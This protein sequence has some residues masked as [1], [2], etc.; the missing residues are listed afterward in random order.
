MRYAILCIAGDLTGLTMAD[1]RKRL[2]NEGDGAAEAGAAPVGRTPA[3]ARYVAQRELAVALGTTSDLE[4]ALGRCLELALEASEMQGGGIYLCTEDGGIDLACHRGLEPPFVAQVRRFEPSSLNARIVQR[5]LPAY[6]DAGQLRDAGTPYGLDPQIR[7]LAALPFSHQERRLGVI[8]VVSHGLSEVPLDARTVLEGLAA[9]MGGAVA[10]LQSEAALRRSERH[11]RLLAENLPDIVIIMDPEGRLAYCNPQVGLYGYDPDEEQGQHFSKFMARAEDRAKAGQCMDRLL[12]Q[13]LPVTADLLFQPRKAEPFAVEFSLRLF[14]ED[15]GRRFVFCVLRDISKRKRAEEA[16]RRSE[17][18]YRST[19]EAMDEAVFVLDRSQRLTMF[20][21]ELLRWR[22]KHGLGGGALMAQPVAEV[23]PFLE[24]R[25]LARWRQAFDSGRSVESSSCAITNYGPVHTEIR[26][27]PVEEEGE[28]ASLVV[29]VRDVTARIEAEEER[30]RL[31]ENLRE[32]Q[33]IESLGRLAGGVAHDLN[34]L[35]APIMGYAEMSL[36]KTE[37]GGGLASYLERILGAAERAQELTKQLLAFGRKRVLRMQTVH[38]NQVVEE[39]EPMVRRIIGEDVSIVSELD[40]QLGAVW[41]DPSHIHH[42]LMNLVVNARDAMP[43]GGRI[44]IRTAN[45]NLDEAFQQRHPEAT[46]GPHVALSVRDDGEGMDEATLGRIFEPFFTTKDQG[47][48]TGLGLSTVHG[49]IQQHG[50]C[51]EVESAL[52]EGTCVRVFL[53]RSEAVPT[54]ED[55]APPAPRKQLLQG[56][57]T[58]LV[59][60]DEPAVRTMICEALGERGYQL[61]AAADAEQALTVIEELD[62]PLHLLLTDVILPGMDGRSLYELVANMR[63]E[64]RVLFMSGYPAAVISR[65]GVL[66]Q[67]VH[68]LQKPFS[69]AALEAKVLEVLAEG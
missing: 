21:Q 46:V 40:P 24:E 41:A 9:Q 63:P 30:Q 37:P 38:L 64:M 27:I 19:M 36:L 33:R 60:E 53:P 5:G 45:R 42:V 1:D 6:A 58:I 59:V 29:V 25:I 16:L 68:L 61:H 50:G 43:A 20:N 3:E 54:I 14:Q 57:H 7:A 4:E 18:L 28:I 35:L 8:V 2:R 52:D 44:T 67:G 47:K 32:A 31:S 66:E 62:E 56:R 15:D 23:L 12:H 69:M 51:I 55:Q 39:V 10:R 26:G 48:G 65:H 13:G 22:A 11:Y 34:N 49:L 17:T